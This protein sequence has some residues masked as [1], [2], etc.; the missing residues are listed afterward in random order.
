VR[1]CPVGVV[2]FCAIRPPVNC[3][4]G[5]DI[6]TGC[7]T[8]RGCGRPVARDVDFVAITAGA[9]T[10]VLIRVCLF[11]VLTVLTFLAGVPPVLDLF[12]VL[13][14]LDEVERDALELDLL[15]LDPLELE[16]PLER[17]PPLELDPLELPPPL[18]P[19]APLELAPLEPPAPA[20]PVPERRANLSAPH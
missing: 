20:D 14:P 11:G 1:P 12:V 6:V 8:V 17:P 15:E 19:P 5:G 9:L 7:V 3:D 13:D 18:E 16:R 2:G 10:V 4:F